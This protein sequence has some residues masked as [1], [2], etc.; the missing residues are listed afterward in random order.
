MCTFFHSA[1]H[2]PLTLPSFRLIFA[3]LTFSLFL[4]FPDFSPPPPLFPDP[5][6]CP[7]DPVP[8]LPLFPFISVLRTQFWIH[9]KSLFISADYRL[10]QLIFILESVVLVPELIGMGVDLFTLRSL[11]VTLSER[12]E[13]CSSGPG[14][15]TCFNGH[16]LAGTDS[17][18]SHDNNNYD[19]KMMIFII[20]F[21]AT[22][23]INTYVFISLSLV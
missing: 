9:F 1:A 14:A 3:F 6:F 13:M 11:K 16:F 18:S 10:R 19:Q 23:Q 7:P 17:D 20:L 21:A 5:V 2:S 8:C 4:H 22:V 15:I 12:I